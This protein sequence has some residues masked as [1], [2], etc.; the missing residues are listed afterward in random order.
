[1]DGVCAYV[2]SGEKEIRQKKTFPQSRYRCV[3]VVRTLKDTAPLI[4]NNGH[5]NRPRK[6]AIIIPRKVEVISR[7]IT[8]PNYH[9]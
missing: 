4:T 3:Y 9:W 2:T 8:V 7:V 6:P 1:M 5:V